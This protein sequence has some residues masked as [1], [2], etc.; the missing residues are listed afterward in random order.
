MALSCFRLNQPLKGSLYEG[1][2]CLDAHAVSNDQLVEIP[3][4]Q[5]WKRSRGVAVIPSFGVLASRNRQVRITELEPLVTLEL[6]EISNRGR[7][8]PPEAIEF[9]ACLKTDVARR[10]RAN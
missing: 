9:A 6:Q 4:K 8:L 3:G 2:V 7:K 5:F 10:M 1:F